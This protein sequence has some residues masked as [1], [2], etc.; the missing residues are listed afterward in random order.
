[1]QA[2]SAYYKNARIV[3]IGNPVIPEGGNLIITVLDETAFQN[4]EEIDKNALWKEIEGLYGIVSPDIDEKA[5]LA[6]AR[7][8]KYESSD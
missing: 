7:I 5:E 4:T 3:P 1:M 8:E 2:Y 6:E